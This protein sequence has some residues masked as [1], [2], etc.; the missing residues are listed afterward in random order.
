MEKISR[1]DFIKS[2]RK[3]IHHLKKNATK[4]ELSRLDFDKL[5]THNAC[6]CIYGQMTGYCESSRAMQLYPKIY[7]DLSYK[8]ISK[9]SLNESFTPLEI[10]IHEG[11]DIHNPNVTEEQRNRD[12]KMIIKFLRGEIKELRK[13]Y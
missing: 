11:D 5:N 4:E 9:D 8:Y 2:V 7:G 1:E 10:F 12:N 13:L 3:E 6:K